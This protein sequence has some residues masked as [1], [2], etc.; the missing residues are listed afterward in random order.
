MP[1]IYSPSSCFCVT[2]FVPAACIESQRTVCAISNQMC[3]YWV[4]FWMSAGT[5]FLVSPLAPQ[6]CSE[7]GSGA[8]LW[9]GTLGHVWLWADFRVWACVIRA[10][11]NCRDMCSVFRASYNIGQVLFWCYHGIFLLWIRL[12]KDRKCLKPASPA[13]AP[14][15][16]VSGAWFLTAAP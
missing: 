13:W 9:E 7:N 1:W 5:A 11:W 15:L 2:A 16:N 8:R 14:Q 4:H 10:V 3:F 12:E 6:I